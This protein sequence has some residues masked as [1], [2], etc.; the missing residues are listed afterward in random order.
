MAEETATCKRTLEFTVP[1]E[2]LEAETGEVIAKLQAKIKLPGFRPG[3]IPP[4]VI[5][6]RYEGEVMNEALQS[7]LP[8]VFTERANKEQLQVVGTPNIKDLHVHK[9]KPITFKAD[10]EV[11]PEIELGGYTELTV[12]YEEPAVTEADVEKRL[13]GIRE[14]KAEY[15]NIDPRPVEDGDFAVVAMKSI[16]GV[17]GKPIEND[18]MLLHIG[19][20]ETMPAFTEA[21]RGMTPGE[22]K[23][24]E[25]E[26]PKDYAHEQ[27]AGRKVTF[28]VK[29]TGLRKKD[30]PEL[31]DEFAQDVGDFKDMEELRAEVRKT[32]LREAEFAAQSAAK[33]ELVEKLVDAHDFPVPDAYV[34]RQIEINLENRFRELGMTADQIRNLKID[35]DELK[36]GQKE[37]AARDVKASLLLG[38]I[39]ERESIGAMQ[40]EVDR[41]VNRI[42]RQLREPMAAV[43]MKLEKDGSIGRIASRIATEKVLSF[44]FDKSRKVAP[45]AK[46]AGDAE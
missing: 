40:D 20:P 7:L 8:R 22:E 16:A 19:N 29:L 14:Q 42:A 37:K 5:R 41:E 45:E 3:K 46:P 36:K 1:Y 26:Y 39:A 11:A 2:E 28:H 21:L 44:L 15:I 23:D 25:L 4:S 31:N 43:R 9:G 33:N 18:E 17:E 35:W 30:L 32:L 12:G 38:K 27:L 13:D 24:V 6:S 34:D 10:F